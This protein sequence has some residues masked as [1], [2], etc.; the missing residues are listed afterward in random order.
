MREHLLPSYLHIHE[1]ISN[2][3]RIMKIVI[4]LFILLNFIFPCALYAQGDLPYVEGEVL[5]KFKK[6]IQNDAS[7]KIQTLNT[8]RFNDVI[9]HLPLNDI[10]LVKVSATESVDNAIKR[11]K[12][13]PNI[14]HAE[15][16]YI[17]HVM[18]ITPN[19][20]LFSS[21]WAL[22]KIKGP[23]AWQLEQ[24]EKTVVIA[25]ADSGID[26]NH[27]DLKD[28]LWLNAN[29]ICDNSIDDD[30]NGYVDDCY[31]I[32]IITG[33][34]NPM[35]DVGHGTHISGIAGATGNNSIG[36]SGINWHVSLMS[37]KF[38]ASDGEGTLADEIEAIEY[39]KKKGAKIFN[40]SYGNY[41]YSNIEKQAIADANNILFVAAACNDNRNNDIY[42]CYPA[43]YD[44]PNLIS[45]AATDENDNLPAF[46]NYGK[47]SV[48]V[49]APGVNI[50]STYLGN[51]YEI[52]DGTSMSAPFVTGLA[53]LILAKNHGLA[54]S[55]IKDR[56]LRT[57]DPLPALQNK[58]LTGARIN[59][60]RSLT[61][62]ITGPY[63]YSISPVK[64]SV[65]ST[66]TIRG[67]NFKNTA[68]TVL[69][70]GDITAPVTSWGN[71]KIAVKVPDGAL[72]GPV[73]VLTSDGASNGTDY[74]VT[75]FPSMTR[76]SF[77]YASN[78]DGKVSL[79]IFSNMFDYPV[80][81]YFRIV[82]ASGK[83]M[84][85]TITL[86]PLEKIIYDISY[87]FG[88]SNDSYLIDCQSE[89]FFAAVL[90]M[91]DQN[92]RTVTFIPHFVSEILD[93]GSP[94]IR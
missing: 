80:N 85:T 50:N 73:R 37:L 40:M 30:G 55:L 86:G 78:E 58:T 42:P 69:F 44:L 15:P 87:H 83:N 93:F 25:Y 21:Q 57:A 23:D 7:R 51:K 6:E 8:M 48:S 20:P 60:Y 49:A 33:S 16:N 52:L 35:D 3:M 11:L 56:I 72:T 38:I 43:S 46:S 12:S 71:D 5:I 68:G 45:V 92:F 66:V 32:N 26:L 54:P 14:E 82:S 47:N 91:S 36:I 64:G 13:D 27:S 76:I 1:L 75:A 59:A 41:D 70:G 34:G 9:K 88:F 90:L 77:P 18:G 84:L 19:D 61:E 89:D 65:G 31:G 94:V 79:L 39:A 24:G 67:S 4:I 63:I 53:A 22:Q 17:K 62:T 81:V 2:H 74:T 10:Y 28:N 29:E